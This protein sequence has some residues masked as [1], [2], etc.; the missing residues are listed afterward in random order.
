MKTIRENALQVL[1]EN[2]K[3]V[4]N[5][6]LSEYVQSCSGSDPNFFRWLFDED[7]ENDFSADLSADQKKAYNEFINEIELDEKL[8]KYIIVKFV[9]SDEESYFITKR[10]NFEKCNLCDCYAGYGIK[11]TCDWAGCYTL[12]NCESSIQSDLLLAVQEHFD[13]QI[14]PYFKERFGTHFSSLDEFIENVSDLNDEDSDIHES[15]DYQKIDL[16]ELKAISE[17]WLAENEHHTECVAWTF[18]DS[19]NFR[20]L[21]LESELG[22][23]NKVEEIDEEEERAILK[24][25]TGAPYIDSGTSASE[26]TENYVF[27]STAWADDPWICSVGKK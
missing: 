10:A 24:E 27:T 4:E 6:T 26:T 11:V 1:K 18:W 2:F 12:D 7:F 23:G 20:S 14:H 22:E 15:F 16:K 17:K 19:H 21:V 8:E 5:S 9:D 25:F 13:T 3:E